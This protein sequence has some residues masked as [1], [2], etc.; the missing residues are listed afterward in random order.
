MI[1]VPLLFTL[2]LAALAQP[3]PAVQDDATVLARRAARELA[4]AWTNDGFKLRDSDWTG[5]F[6]PGKS[7]LIQVSLFAGNRYWFS[8]A[9]TGGG[10]LA[11]GIYD[12]SGKPLT[13]ESYEDGPR[14]AAGFR[15]DA[16][17]PYLVKIEQRGDQASSFC[18]VYSYK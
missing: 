2:G 11:L 13:V 10:A 9:A 1:L 8:A 7:Q 6:T 18:L 17:G 4:A 12:E 3:A 16:S 15:P 5:S 14:A